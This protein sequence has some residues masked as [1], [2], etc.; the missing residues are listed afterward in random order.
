MPNCRSIPP[1]V[2]EHARQALITFF[3]RRHQFAN[4]EDLAQETLA[5]LWSRQDFEFDK[6]EEFLRVCYGFAGKISLAGYRT[7][8]KHDAEQL[9]TASR[10]TSGF[11]VG[12]NPVEASLLLDEVVRIAKAELRDQDWKLIENAALEERDGPARRPDPMQAN[13]A[14]VGLFRARRKLKEL[15]GWGK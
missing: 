8:R 3:S 14:R 2:W 5:V 1:A 15:T 7:A 6:E 13:R 4:A 12:L 9:D 10:P 11:N